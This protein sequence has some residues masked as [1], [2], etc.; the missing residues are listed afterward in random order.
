MWKIK[1]IDRYEYMDVLNLAKSMPFY[2]SRA[3]L[4][5]LEYLGIPNQVRLYEYY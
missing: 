5:I 3:T 1:A 4:P 2:Y